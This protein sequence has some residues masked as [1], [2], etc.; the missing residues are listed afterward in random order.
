MRLA[1]RFNWYGVGEGGS[2]WWAQ[3]KIWKTHMICSVMMIVLVVRAIIN[4]IIIV[5]MRWLTMMMAVMFGYMRLLSR[6]MAVVVRLLVMMIMLLVL[7]WWRWQIMSTVGQMRR[8]LHSNLMM[9]VMRH[10]TLRCFKQRWLNMRYKLCHFECGP[11]KSKANKRIKCFCFPSFSHSHKEVVSIEIVFEHR[12]SC[13]E[14]LC[15]RFT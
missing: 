14:N 6:G 3:K 9:V 1:Q 15:H 2:V 8:M 13:G 11:H 12:F 4:V 7:G 5:L 10:M